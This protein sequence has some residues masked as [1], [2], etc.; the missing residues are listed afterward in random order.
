[1]IGSL[2]NNL[3]LFGASFEKLSFVLFDI[4]FTLNENKVYFEKACL[5]SSLSSVSILCVL[6]KK[7]S[8]D[9]VC[10]YVILFIL[11][12]PISGFL[13]QRYRLVY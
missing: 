1:M 12:S 6:D 7:E 9:H 5:L 8:R 2:L 4:C 10:L 13:G 11:L 3:P